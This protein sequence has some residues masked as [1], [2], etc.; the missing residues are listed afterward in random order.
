MCSAVPQCQCCLD[1]QVAESCRVFGSIM[2]IVDPS[3]PAE[4]QQRQVGGRLLWRVTGTAA[5]YPVQQNALAC[6]W[7]NDL[8]Q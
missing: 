1:V 6:C 3:L 7:A 8:H 2:A 5:C 4:E